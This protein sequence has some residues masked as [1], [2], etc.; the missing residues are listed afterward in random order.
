MPNVLNAEANP[1]AKAILAREAT[2]AFADV[3]L[4]RR[5][6]TNDWIAIVP[7]VNAQMKTIKEAKNKGFCRT[8]INSGDHKGMP[9]RKIRAT[10][11]VASPAKVKDEFNNPA[12]SLRLGRYRIIP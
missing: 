12:L 2:I 7:S 4:A 5:N 10:N 3:K 8:N 11:T 9:A 6:A 1:T